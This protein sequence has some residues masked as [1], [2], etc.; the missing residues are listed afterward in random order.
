MIR[1]YVISKYAELLELPKEHALCVNLEKSTHNWA[2]NRST[3][4]G[5]VAAADNYRHMNRYKHKFLQIQYNLKRSPQLKNKILNGVIKTA[6]IMEL[7]PHALWPEGPWA[8]TLEERIEKNMKKD[9]VSVVLQDPNYKGI[10]KCRRCKS[11]KTTY[12][13]MQTRSADEPMTVFITCHN[14]DSRWKS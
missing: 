14:C 11:H 12:Y 6:S 2:I 1:D 7:S 8:K 3:S 5:D 10:F 4:L 13:E 9:Y